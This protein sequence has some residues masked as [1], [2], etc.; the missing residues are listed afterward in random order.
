MI[1]F[2]WS[3]QLMDSKVLYLNNSPL[4]LNTNQRF[5]YHIRIS[6]A[7]L[8]LLLATFPFVLILGLFNNSLFPTFIT[9]NDKIV[10]LLVFFIETYLY[11]RTFLSFSI[12][13]FN[14]IN[15]NTFHLFL[16]TCILGGCVFTE[17]LQHWVNPNRSFDIL[18]M[19]FNSIGSSLGY[20]LYSY[21]HDT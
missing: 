21:I 20:L 7:R 15:L 12:I 18:D 3:N 16:L 17:Y 10:H 9:S 8:I 2:R 11:L 19:L 14:R 6:I 1:T 4:P 13:L 5:T